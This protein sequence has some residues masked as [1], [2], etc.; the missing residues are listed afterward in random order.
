MMRR[1]QLGSTG[2]MRS[3]RRDGRGRAGIRGIEIRMTKVQVV[4]AQVLPVE[5][6]QVIQVNFYNTE[7]TNNLLH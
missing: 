5:V 1:S 4:Q 7:T 2:L 6:V 3:T